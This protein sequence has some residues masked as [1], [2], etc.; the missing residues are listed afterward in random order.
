MPENML[1]NKVMCRQFIRSVAFVNKKC[2]TCLRKT[3]VS[4]LSGQS[5]YMNLTNAANFTHSILKHLSELWGKMEGAFFST[6]LLIS[7]PPFVF[8]ICV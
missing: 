4:F 3:F 5:S 2:F 1:K 8:H 6:N 7:P